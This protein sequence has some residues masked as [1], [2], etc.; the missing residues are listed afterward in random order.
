MGRAPEVLLSKLLQVEAADALDRGVVRRE[1]FQRARSRGPEVRSV[2]P[3][4]QMQLDQVVKGLILFV[5]IRFRLKETYVQPR[6]ESSFFGMLGLL[7]LRK[8]C[9]NE[10][11][12][13]NFVKSLEL[14]AFTTVNV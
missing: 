12:L 10:R 14:S 11:A 8:T 7:M 9:T 1:R 5:K 13:Q 4:R 3:C 6:S 2:A